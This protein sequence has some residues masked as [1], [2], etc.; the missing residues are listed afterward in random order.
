MILLILS[1]Y[2]IFYDFFLHKKLLQTNLS[3]NILYLLFHSLFFIYFHKNLRILYGIHRSLQLNVLYVL[4]IIHIDNI[5]IRD[6]FYIKFLIL[7]YVLDNG[8]YFLPKKV[9]Q[10]INFFFFLNVRKVAFKFKIFSLTILWEVH[11]K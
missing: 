11:F 7:F 2:L 9:H 3:C 6:N 8:V 5:S 10:V 1:F 4:Q